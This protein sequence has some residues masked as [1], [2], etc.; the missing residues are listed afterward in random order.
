MA[1]GST[2]TPLPPCGGGGDGGGGVLPL[3][4]KGKAAWKG[5]GGV[6]V[7]FPLAK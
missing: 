4:A 1:E 3:K 2:A 5:G 7:I 6:N